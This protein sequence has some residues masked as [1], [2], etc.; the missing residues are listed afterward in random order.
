MATDPLGTTSALEYALMVHEMVDALCTAAGIGEQIDKC[1][2]ELARILA[3]PSGGGGGS[4]VNLPAP[5]GPYPIP[6]FTRMAELAS[7]SSLGGGGGGGSSGIKGCP[8]L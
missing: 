4:C 7:G 8:S 2:T 6:S 3:N 1:F 5:A